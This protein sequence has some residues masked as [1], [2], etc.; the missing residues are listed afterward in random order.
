MDVARQVGVGLVGLGVV[1]VHDILPNLVLPEVQQRLKL[2]A[3]CDIDEARARDAAGMFDVPKR[4]TDAAELAADPDVEIVAIAT[5]VAHHLAPALAAI[6]AGKHVYLQKTMTLDVADADE[7]ITAGKKA[8]VI[9]AAAPGNHLRSPS[10]KAI[11]KHLDN[12][13]IGKVCWGR[14]QKGTRHDEDARRQP[15]G[16]LEEVDPSWYYKSGGGPLRDAAVYDI[17]NVTYLLGPAKRVTAMSGI[18]LPTREWKDNII[19]VEMD[20]NT[21]FILDFGE[22]RYVVFSSH[23]IRGSRQV[24]SLELYGEWGSIFTGGRAEGG[25]ELYKPSQNRDRGGFV[26]EQVEVG[27]KEPVGSA[28]GGF[29]H[30][31]VGD[32][33]AVADSIDNGTPIEFTAEQARHVVEIIDKVYESA[34]VGVALDLATTFDWT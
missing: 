14:A 25:Y 17:Q 6:A 26:E 22:N 19:E 9:V 4:Y 34:R 30:Y 8:G 33:A 16:S 24:P 21:H 15:G 31:I 1:S 27:A 3:V 7:L 13:D 18:A 29:N 12:G 10:M 23:F 11:R 28:Q 20:D 5:P 32:L 2:V